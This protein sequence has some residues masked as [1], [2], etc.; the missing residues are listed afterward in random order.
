MNRLH[1][2]G[3]VL[4]GA[5]LGAIGIEAAHRSAAPDADDAAKAEAP[6][7]PPPVGTVR[8]E[9]EAAQQVQIRLALLTGASVTGDQP[10]FA[11]A[12]D[13]SALA[14]IASEA[15]AASAV[16]DASSREAARLAALN[17]ADAGAALKDVEAARAQAAAD[18]ARLTLACQRAG[19]EYGPGLARLGCPALGELAREAAGGEL[20]LLRLDFSGAALR[21]GDSITVD[22][23][24]GTAQVRVLGPAAAGDSQLQSVGVLALL[25]GP[26]APRAGVGRV[27]AAHRRLGAAQAG[28]LVPR[29]AIVRTE[30][31]LF[32]WRPAAKDTY[33]RVPL[34]GAVASPQGWIVPAGRLKAGDSVVVSGAGTLLGLEHAAPAAAE[35]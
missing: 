19:L 1:A 29:E 31:G 27:L 18:K 16:A 10:G 17:K 30:G 22:L 35:D 32:A 9:P 25:R 14:A 13:L 11:R 4:A 24:P 21:P 28:L 26:L 20:T 7:A 12:L 33:E 8:L 2:A 23:A 34:D 3:L 6:E 5:L 15:Q